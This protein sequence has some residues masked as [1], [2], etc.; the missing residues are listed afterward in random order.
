LHPGGDFFGDRVDRFVKRSTVR[1]P[2]GGLS[3][4]ERQELRR[5]KQVG[6]QGVDDLAEGGPAASDLLLGVG[7]GPRP[8]LGLD[9]ATR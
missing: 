3:H 8:P 1:H 5:G 9:Y 4:E 6:D 7:Q 2:R